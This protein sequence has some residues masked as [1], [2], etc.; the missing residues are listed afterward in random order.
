MAPSEVEAEL[1]EHPAIADVAVVGMRDGSSG[2]RVVAAVVPAAGAT[3]DSGELRAWAKERL[4]AYK[5]PREFVAVEALPT[6]LLGKV[7]RT[8]V[9]DQLAARG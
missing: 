8:Q 2:E 1:R 7:L 9:R 5:V 6:S 3:I 4:A